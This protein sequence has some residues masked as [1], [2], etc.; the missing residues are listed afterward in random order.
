MI[1]QIGALNAP[2]WFD[3]KR[4]PF[5]RLQKQSLAAQPWHLKRA[6]D[7]DACGGVPRSADPCFIDRHK[8]AHSPAPGDQLPAAGLTLWHSQLNFP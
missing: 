7:S 5:A 8:S 3:H 1:N 6:F 4:L 2:I